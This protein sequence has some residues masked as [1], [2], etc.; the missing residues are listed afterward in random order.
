[1]DATKRPS[2]VPDLKDMTLSRH[3]INVKTG[4]ENISCL[5]LDATCDRVAVTDR[6]GTVFIHD[7]STPESPEISS[8][9]LSG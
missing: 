4:A 2:E 8:F 5:L 3:V 6:E 1:M 7:Y 9:H